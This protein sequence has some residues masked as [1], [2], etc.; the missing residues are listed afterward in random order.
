MKKGFDKLA[1][2]SIRIA[3]K[4]A[5]LL[6]Q[7]LE[8]I[9]KLFIKWFPV[10]DIA[11]GAWEWVKNGFKFKD[12]PFPAWNDVMA[13]KDMIDTV[14]NLHK[15]IREMVEQA[16]NYFE[17][18]KQVIDAVSKIPDVDSTHKAIDVVEGFKTG[19]DQM[20][21]A[22]KK[23]KEADKERQTQIDALNRTG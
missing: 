14:L 9:G 19:S 16:K 21:E 22:E 2:V 1:E 8:R 6:N 23:Y 10:A 3:T 11:L 5:N 7:I 20:K 17:G 13:I 12:L 18:F 4:C 15:A